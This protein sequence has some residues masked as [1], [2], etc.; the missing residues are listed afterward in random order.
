MLVAY[1]PGA[2]VAGRMAD[3]HGPRPVMLSAALLIGF[4]FA[5]CSRGVNL[6]MLAG[7]FISVGLGT[8]AT[9]GLPTA[10]I[11]RWFIK[12]RGPMVGIVIA[13]AGIGGFIFAPLADY[14]I[15]CYGWRTAYLMIAV[16]YGTVIG[17]SA[18]FLISDPTAKQQRPFS[19]EAVKAPGAVRQDLAFPGVTS[20]QAFKSGAFW[21][22]SVL[23]V[24]SFMPNFF[25]SAHFVPFVT[26][27]GINS[28]AAASAFGTIGIMSVAGRL[29]MSAAAQRIG[30][31]KSLAI[32]YG[33]AALSIVW[34]MF[35]TGPKGFYLFV[36]VYG[37]FNG[38]TIALLGNAVGLFFGLIALSELLGVFL[39][40]G[41][42]AAAVSPFLSGLSF[43]LTGSYLTAMIFAVVC[44]CGAGFCALVLKPPKDRF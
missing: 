30:C 20:A 36:P 22:M 39:G 26:D 11:Q 28:S 4:G 7:A 1:A 16:L 29:V 40:I 12:W 13:G 38:S 5:G 8:G 27:R 25:V 24:L 9:L 3:R 6:F 35:A 10:T 14:L 15:A 31:M 2:F 32:C 23:F 19:D 18:S 34:L 33:F 43:D 17:V 21:G 41:I 44:Y 37:F 42:L